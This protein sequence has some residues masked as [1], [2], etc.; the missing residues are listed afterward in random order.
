MKNKK[1]IQNQPSFLQTHF[2][3]V[4]A[5]TVKIQIAFI[6]TRQLESWNKA[7]P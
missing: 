2:H 6:S 3:P 5:F 4:C 7:T 1:M